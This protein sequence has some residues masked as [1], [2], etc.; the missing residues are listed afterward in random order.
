[1]NA[2]LYTRLLR[3]WRRILFRFRRDRM[4]QDL[5]EELE[6][7][8]EQKRAENRALGLAPQPALE[9]ARRQMGNV[10]IAQEDCR[11]TWSFLRWE[12]LWQDLRHATRMYGRTPVFTAVCVLS[13]ALGIGGN[14]AMFSLV[15]SLLLRP[16]PYFEPSR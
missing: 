16:L 13:M 1:M 6:F 7:H 8:L 9:L 15:N 12:R 14:A 10:A 5:A 2:S 4:S 3:G 11:D